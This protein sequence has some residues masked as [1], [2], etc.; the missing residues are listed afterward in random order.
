M[1]Y[2]VLSSE[3]LYDG[4]ILQLVVDEIRYRESGRASAREVVVKDDFVV[5][6]PLLPDG[7]LVPAAP[8]SSVAD[9][10][11]RWNIHVVAAA[12]PRPVSCGYPR[13]L[14]RAPRSS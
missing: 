14:A 6:I 12:P 9:D 2:D 1:N 11:S 8:K 13:H 7:R 3:V 4:K 5:A 10:P